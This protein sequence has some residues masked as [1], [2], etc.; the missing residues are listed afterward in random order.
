MKL[1][2]LN[3]IYVS[4]NS[5]REMRKQARITTSEMASYVGIKS[6]KTYESWEKGNSQPNI[7]QVIAIC[8]ACN[9]SPANFIIEQMREL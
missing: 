6:R 8:I 9:V 7:N 2:E 3:K 5:I 4:G 1:M